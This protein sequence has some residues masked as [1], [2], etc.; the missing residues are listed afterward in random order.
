MFE[1]EDTGAACGLAGGKAV[2]AGISVR[3]VYPVITQGA[4]CYDRERESL[5]NRAET[6]SQPRA[7]GKAFL[8]Q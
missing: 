2:E 6:L 7:L 4:E 3:S 5:G 8:N 1:R